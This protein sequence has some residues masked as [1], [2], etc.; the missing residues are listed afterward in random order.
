MNRS[1][2]PWFRLTIVTGCGLLATCQHQEVKIGDREKPL[3]SEQRAVEHGRKVLAH[4]RQANAE[5][6]PEARGE[7]RTLG[8]PPGTV[9][10]AREKTL[11]GLTIP[12]A[13]SEREE[14]K[15]ELERK[16]R[17]ARRET[18]R[19]PGGV[20][21][22]TAGELRRFEEG[23]PV[24]WADQN[25]AA[26]VS[27]GADRLKRQAERPLDGREVVVGLWEAG[28]VARAS[29]QLF[30]NR[31]Q[32][33]DDAPESQHATHVGGT[34]I[35][36][37]QLGS[38]TAGMAPQAGIHSYDVREIISELVGELATE[39][40]ETGKIYLTNNSWGRVS[41]WSFQDGSYI[42]VGN[43]SDD[44]VKENDYVRGFGQYSQD[45]QLFDNVVEVFPYAAL[46]FSAGNDRGEWAPVAGTPWLLNGDPDF[47]YL[48]DPA[49]H[50]PSDRRW[51]EDDGQSGF[52]TISDTAAAKNVI[53]VG[54]VN[55]AVVNGE[56]SPAAGTMSNF[57]A[58]GP[59]DD[60]R[61]KPDVVGN[62]VGLRSAS[63]GGDSALAVLSGTSMSAPNVT[64]TA[65]LLTDLYQRIYPGE[66]MRASMLKG[67]LIHTA[68]DL[69]N[70]GPDFRFGWGLV[71][72]ER[73][74]ALLEDDALS[75]SR[76][77]LLD[78]RVQ[79]EDR[80]DVFTVSHDGS[81]SLKVTLCWTD[82]YGERTSSHDSRE[83]CL[84]HD[85]NLEVIGPDGTLHQP[86]IMPWTGQWSDELLNADAV[87]G[88]NT[89]DNVEQV[90]VDGAAAG[91]YTVRVSVAGRLL[92]LGQ[93][94][95]V[96]VDG[97]SFSPEKPVR[98]EGSLSAL[99]LRIGGTAATLHPFQSA[100]DTSYALSNGNENVVSAEISITGIVS[101]WP[102]SEG[103]AVL[104]LL[105]QNEFGEER[106][107][108]ILVR[109]LSDDALKAWRQRNDLPESG[110]GDLGDS[111]G[112]GVPDLLYFA[113]GILD[114]ERV[115]GPAQG[116]GMSAQAGLPEFQPSPGGEALILTYSRSKEAAESTEYLIEQ[117]A[118]L[119]EGWQ[120]MPN[121]P[122]PI[123]LAE[124]EAL[125][126]LQLQLPV[127][128]GKL[129]YRMR[130]RVAG[131]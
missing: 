91:E 69:G 115:V 85:L 68:T 95:T 111:S 90:V 129:F 65:A 5:E 102:R 7:A 46:F 19:T 62:G 56:R 97:A 14:L 77:R 94:Y 119:R 53:A 23:E 100:L 45:S 58:Y 6:E 57:S 47:S 44:G 110:E 8:V 35:G 10:E 72:G 1:R 104:D 54:A 67:L 101:V 43:F 88:V 83:R 120:P 71:D 48:Y 78:G 84:F 117:S 98:R 112:N 24:I 21:N 37:E 96:L 17:A 12:L 80:E 25:L 33:F 89:V 3:Q 124:D 93:I 121:P 81:G 79:G 50:P 59:T 108:Q 11:L 63:S 128:A 116:E 82:P 40:G 74:A 107:Q 41:G 66:S 18:K 36:N 103:E 15:K 22:L 109:V 29:H 51:M 49:S 4:D 70:P 52:G 92:E 114:V 106:S 130:V 39:E 127:S 27:T 9:S 126:V 32:N 20:P 113:F 2:S 131:G 87:R 76:S 105:A 30:G 38:A 75:S 118:T 122:E 26:A 34:I 42:W 60:G 125:E 16:E 86:F 123:L 28:G 55:D 73:A 99:D 61:I 13:E 31:L 64:G